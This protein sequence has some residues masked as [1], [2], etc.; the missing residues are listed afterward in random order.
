[1][2]VAGSYAYIANSG[3]GLAVVDVS[4]PAAPTVVGAVPGRSALAVAV[5]EGYA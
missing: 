5:A 4:D 3:P 1:V 2:A